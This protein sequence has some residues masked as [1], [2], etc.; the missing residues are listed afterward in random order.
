MN[1]SI[2][3]I[4]GERYGRLTVINMSDERGLK[5]QVKWDC[6]CDCGNIS[7]VIGSSLRANRT[8]SCGC[9]QK[10]ATRK[11]SALLNESSLGKRYGKLKVVEVEYV[12]DTSRAY[13]ICLCDCGNKARVRLDGVKNGHTISCGCYITE[14]NKKRIGKLNPSY[15]ATITDEERIKN[16][17]YYREELSSWRNK[18]FSRDDY[19]CVICN[20]GGVLN[21]HHLNA[22]HWDIEGRF[23]IDN[24]VTLCFEHHRD[25]HSKYST[26]GNTKEQFDAYLNGGLQYE[27]LQ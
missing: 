26:R 13:A 25:F 22:Y 20:K 8:K 11:R 6:L 1:K 2:K 4:L 7:T 24:G 19:K 5:G 17:T 23:D 10:D 18:V 3:N 14:F 21:A 16:R 9:L 27:A 15:D 12:Q